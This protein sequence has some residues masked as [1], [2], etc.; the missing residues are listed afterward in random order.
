MAESTSLSVGEAPRR[1]AQV[2]RR[3]SSL[4]SVPRG[5]VS[6]AMGEPFSPTDPRV[7]EAAIKALQTGRTRYAP[8]TGASELREAIARRLS[9]KHVV[10]LESHNVVVTHGG[11]AGLAATILALVNP[12]DRV[13]IPEPTYSLYADQVALVGGEIDYVANSPDGSL[14]LAALLPR[15]D[16]ARMVILCNP[17]NPTG[18]VQSAHDIRAIEA[19]IARTGCYLLSDEAY[20]DIVFDGLSFFSALDL[21]DVPDLVICC[22]TFSKSYAMTGWRLGFVTA[23]APVAQAINLVHRTFNGALNTFVQDAGLAA[24]NVSDDELVAMAASYQ[25]RRDVVVAKLI[26]IPRVEVATPQGAFY[27]FPRITSTYSSDDLTQQLA[28]GG[29]LVRS[30]AEYGPSGE[31]RIRVSF[32]TDLETLHEGLSRIHNVLATLN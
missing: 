27:A 28:D 1:V 4:G 5:A 11:S 26:E 8:L 31:G 20:A 25:Q 32:A 21:T 29:V 14:D 19:V 13:V 12:G 17:G 23:A 2:S 18:A 10:D 16:G 30:G 9:A 6:L 22:G 15:L 3:P 24:L 7:I